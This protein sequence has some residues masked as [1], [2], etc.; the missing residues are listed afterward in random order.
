M[1][2]SQEESNVGPWKQPLETALGKGTLFLRRRMQR[3]IRKGNFVEG[4]RRRSIKT[5]YERS[6]RIWRFIGPPAQ[7]YRLGGGR[8]TSVCPRRITFCAASR[9]KTAAGIAKD[10]WRGSCAQH[11]ATVLWQEDETAQAHKPQS[12]GGK[13]ERGGEEHLFPEIFWTR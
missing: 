6:V 13:A 3:N 7:G 10:A 2:P 12:V 9:T 1:S 4:S 8:L 5:R 11:N